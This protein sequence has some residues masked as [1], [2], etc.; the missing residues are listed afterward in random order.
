MQ[1]DRCKVVLSTVEADIGDTGVSKQLEE[2][3]VGFSE[4]SRDLFNV[5]C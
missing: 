4:D 3:S 5:S 2:H 1:L